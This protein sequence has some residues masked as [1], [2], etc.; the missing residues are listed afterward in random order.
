T[1]LFRSALSGLEIL[2]GSLFP[3]AMPWA[4]LFVPFWAWKRAT[5]YAKCSM[6]LRPFR[7][8]NPSWIP[9]SQGDALGCLVWPLRG[10]EAGNWLR[11]MQHA[12]APRSEEHT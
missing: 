8:R 2:P 12:V 4:V 7:A 5:G 11:Q 9:L 3:R 6:L 1:T 10:V